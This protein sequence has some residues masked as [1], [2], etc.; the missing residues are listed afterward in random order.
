MAGL[1]DKD[2]AWIDSFLGKDSDY[3]LKQNMETAAKQMKIMLDVFIAQGFSRMEALTILT[4]T[5]N[6]Q[7]KK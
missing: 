3:E 1:S 6:G 4:S 2:K 7:A 5:I